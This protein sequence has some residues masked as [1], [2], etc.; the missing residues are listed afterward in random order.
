M[1]VKKIAKVGSGLYA[2]LPK[3][4]CELFG[5]GKGDPI[6]VTYIPAVGFLVTK[7]HPE[8]EVA[9]QIRR[10]E[11]MKN[12]MDEMYVEFRRKV[13][14]LERMVVNNIS[15]RL[16]GVAYEKGREDEV[17]FSGGFC[18]GVRK[19][20]VDPLLQGEIK[21]LSSKI[22]TGSHTESHTRIQTRIQT[23][24]QTGSQK[25]SNGVQK[26]HRRKRGRGKKVRE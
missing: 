2:L 24:S 15:L 1:A 11:S 12:F 9:I 22:L 19:N 23:G 10:L 21:L 6:V 18:G 26:A 5:F 17:D 8:G 3:G 4:D 16:L 13:K 20:Y 14:A 25:K 7:Q